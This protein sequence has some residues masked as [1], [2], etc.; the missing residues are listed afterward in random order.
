MTQGQIIAIGGGGLCEKA[1]AG[2]D[3]YVLEQSQTSQP[4]IGFLGTA[5][6]DSD[7][8]CLKFYSRFSKLNCQPSHLT[9]FHRTPNLAAWVQQQDI[10]Y[11]GGGNTLTMLAIWEVWSLVPLL[12]EAVQNGTVLAGISAG[13]V[14]WFE[15]GVTDAR[16][17]GLGLIKCL[18]FISGSCC[19]HYSADEARQPTFEEHVATGKLPPGIAID[20]GAAVHFVDGELQRIISGR[21]NAA[22][23]NVVPTADGAT[24]QLIESAEVLRLV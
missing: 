19:P 9:F 14:C 15:C 1:K 23:Y 7:S 18:D 3:T 21:E 2:L 17:G 20:D 12:K 10:I 8:A 24:S 5:S 4:K 11:V 22:A 13:A 6:G 16:A